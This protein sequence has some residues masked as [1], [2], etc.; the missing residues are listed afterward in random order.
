[1]DYV[2]WAFETV[3]DLYVRLFGD[4]FHVHFLIRTVFLL[5]TVWLVIVV[6]FKIFKYF[7]GQL[8]VLMFYH[9]F[10]RFWNY[11]FVE[12]PAEWIY[13]HYYSKD[14]PNLEGTYLR[15]TD[16]AKR[17]RE[18]LG[19]LDYGMAVVKVRNAERRFSYFL[20]SLST[21]W[22]VAFG[23][24]TEF[25]PPLPET[26]ENGTVVGGQVEDPG[27]EQ[28]IPGETEEDVNENEINDVNIGGDINVYLPGTIDPAG[29]GTGEIRLVLNE[30][31]R[32]G[33]W[34]RS[35]PGISGF[36]VIQVLWGDVILHYLGYYVPDDYV[37]GLYWLRVRT[38]DGNTGYLSSSLVE[39]YR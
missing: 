5:M 32:G 19:E 11:M 35:G 26:P 33:A 37:S 36:F 29:W 9:G 18:L 4:F 16:K 13:I 39:V 22:I 20:L 6:G 31:G 17:N 30:A 34:L 38:P 12:T 8:F 3:R 21:L 27:L 1:M 28:Y 14:L 23:L 10:F 15:L 24:Y 2:I 7:V 25:F